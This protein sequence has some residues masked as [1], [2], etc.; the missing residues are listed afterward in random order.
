[1]PKSL[2]PSA[3]QAKGW[4]IHGAQRAQPVATGR[5]W[6]RDK[7]GSNRPIGNRWQPTATVSERM[8]RRGSTVR[9]RQRA[10][11]KASKWPSFVLAHRPIVALRSQRP[12]PRP[13][14]GV[15]AA[16][17]FWL[18]QKP[19]PRR[20]ASLCKRYSEISRSTPPPRAVHAGHFSKRR[21]SAGREALRAGGTST[22][23]VSRSTWRH[24][25]E[26]V[27]PNLSI[28][29]EGANQ[30]AQGAISVS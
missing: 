19:A 27:T 17:R 2:W 3:I 24:Q 18:E 15:V 22:F 21:V 25:V 12:I 13:V 10:L 20:S 16:L 23:V 9:V 30:S 14:P 7:N 1:M 29:S 4:S 28:A 11:R 5:K 26:P 8:V 6:E